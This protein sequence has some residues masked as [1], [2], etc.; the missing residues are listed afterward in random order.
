MFSWV[1][2]QRSPLADFGYALGD[3]VEAGGYN[4]AFPS[5]WTLHHG[6]KKVT[7]TVKWMDD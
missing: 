7:S 4:S 1:T 3:P 5:L 2:G 6:T